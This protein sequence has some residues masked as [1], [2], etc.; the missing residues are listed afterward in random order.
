MTKPW[1]R[2]ITNKS[3]DRTILDVNAGEDFHFEGHYIPNYQWIELLK[4]LGYEVEYEHIS[5]EEMEE[6]C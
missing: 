5:D 2:Y 3:G 4:I 6:M 1:I